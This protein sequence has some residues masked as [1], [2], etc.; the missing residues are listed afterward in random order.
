[1][2]TYILS[3]CNMKTKQYSRYQCQANSFSEA[4]EMAQKALNGLP[5]L[6]TGQKEARHASFNS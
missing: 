1:M 5:H 3:M 4:V 6:A 2:R